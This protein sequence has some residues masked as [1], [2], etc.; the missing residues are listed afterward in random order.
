MLKKSFS[1]FKTLPELI[2][3]ILVVLTVLLVV[4]SRNGIKGYRAFVLQ[5]GSMSPAMPVGNL[6]VTRPVAEYQKNDVITF[7]TNDQS[8]NR[9]QTPTTHRIV[10]V[11]VGEN[12]GYQ[13][14]GDGNEDP[15]PYITPASSVIGKVI[16]SL[17]YFGWLVNFARTQNGFIAL[18]VIPGTIIIYS[19]LVNIKNELV[20]ILR[21]KHETASN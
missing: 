11:R 12:L 17:P 1:A 19:E 20:K 3:F 5:S 6:I 7:Y 18:V 8:G 14:K 13:T 15:D 4:L 2:L 21:R 9:N 16:I 10:D